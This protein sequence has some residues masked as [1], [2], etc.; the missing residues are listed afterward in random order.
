MASTLSAYLRETGR[1][2]LRYMAVGLIGIPLA[3]LYA[4]ARRAD[5][6]MSVVGVT[7][8]VLG[9]VTAFWLWRR[10]GD[11]RIATQTSRETVESDVSAAWAELVNRA[12]EMTVP[13]QRLVLGQRADEENLQGPV[14]NYFCAIVEQQAAAQINLLVEEL[15]AKTPMSQLAEEQ[16]RHSLTRRESQSSPSRKTARPEQRQPAW[17]FVGQAQNAHGLA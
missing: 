1:L 15:V 3:A 5:W 16:Y 6:N 12:S 9:F 4:G 7:L 11:W 2:Y 17:S 14:W 10:L 13:N 8:G